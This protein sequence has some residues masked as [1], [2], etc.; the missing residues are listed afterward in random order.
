MI[1]RQHIVIHARFPVKS[2]R[3]S[4]RADFYQI[5][6]PR[7]RLRQEHQMPRLLT[8]PA[9]VKTAPARDIDLA[10]DDRPD[11]L[12]HT[13]LIQIHRPVHHAVIRNRQRVLPQRF[14]IGNQIGNPTDAVKKTV[15]RMHVQMHKR[16]RHRCLRMQ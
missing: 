12:F 8:L 7:V 16:I 3:P 15:L 6:I 11:P 1:P 13:F 2:L 14:H 4:L 9:L 5:P 10:P